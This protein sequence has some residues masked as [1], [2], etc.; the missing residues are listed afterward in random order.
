MECAEDSERNGETKIGRGD[1]FVE[2]VGAGD[3]CLGGPQGDEEK[4]DAGAAHGNYRARSSEEEYEKDA[5]HVGAGR[6]IRVLDLGLFPGQ[7]CFR[8]YRHGKRMS[9]QTLG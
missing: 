4:Q 1:E 2:A 3:V 7:Y 5:V 8:L 6:C 9:C